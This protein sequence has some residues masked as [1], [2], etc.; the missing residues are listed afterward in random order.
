MSELIDIYTENGEKTGKTKDKHDVKEKGEYGLHVMI[1]IKLEDGTYPMQQRSLKAKYGPGEWDVTGGGVR[2]GET[3]AEAAVR[4][5]KEELGVDISKDELVL[6][7][8]DMYSWHPET[9]LIV[10]IYGCRSKAVREDFH[11]DG[12]EVN[13]LRFVDYDE[14]RKHV[15]YNKN[16]NFIRALEKFEN[17]R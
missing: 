13:D 6:L 7:G 3:S 5:A 14:F 15:L 10:H 2:A 8:K 1:I 4:E 9:G 12:Y 17:K 16:E 11:I